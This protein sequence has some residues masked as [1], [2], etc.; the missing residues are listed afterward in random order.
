MNQKPDPIK[1]IGRASE[2]MRRLM[3]AGLNFDD[4]QLPI[5][6]KVA[7]KRIVKAWKSAIY[8]STKSQKIARAIMGGNY[9]GIEENMIHFKIK[10]TKKQLNTLSE[11]RYSADILEACKDTHLLIA[12]FPMS[13]SDIYSRVDKNTLDV[14]CN[15]NDVSNEQGY[16]VIREKCTIRWNLIKKEFV[17]GSFRKRE[18]DQLELLSEDEKVPRS[19]LVVYVVIGNYLE[20]KKCLFEYKAGNC[21]DEDDGGNRMRVEGKCTNIFGK[22]QILDITSF[23]SCSS[24]YDGP[25][26]GLFSCKK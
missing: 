1:V 6:N 21:S 19:N 2:C 4:F 13:I 22:H 20:T 9:F 7:R 18:E 25:G 23:S 3:E 8:E 24:I 26:L 5:T 12:T 15:I 17:S 11:V 16:K 14:L 10:P